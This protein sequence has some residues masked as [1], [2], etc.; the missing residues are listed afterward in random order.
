MARY[1]L[2]IDDLVEA[3]PSHIDTRNTVLNIAFKCSKEE[4]I[5]KHIREKKK[6]PIKEIMLFTSMSRKFLEKWR[7]YILVLILILSTNDYPYIRSYFNIEVGEK[8]E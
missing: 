6:L 8:H 7:K 1:K 4:G 2:T 5:T 3:S